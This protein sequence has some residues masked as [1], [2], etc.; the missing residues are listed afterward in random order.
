V[1]AP[2]HETFGMLELQETW[3]SE[4]LKRYAEEILQAAPEGSI[5]FGGTDAGRCAVS[6]YSESHV[7]GRPILTLT[8]NALADT[9]YLNYLNSMYGSRMSVPTP[10]DS[11]QAFQQYMTAAQKRLQQDA[12]LPGEQVQM[13]AGRVQ[14]SGQ[15]AVMQINGLLVLKTLEKN[16]GRDFYLEE[17]FAVQML[18][19]H[20]EPCGPIFRLHREA[21]E[22]LGKGLIQANHLYWTDFLQE[23]FGE[24][25]ASITNLDAVLLYLDGNYDSDFQSGEAPSS[26]LKSVEARKAF[27]KLRGS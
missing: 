19:P 7:G 5:Y 26:L 8:Q 20:M 14:V 6:C 16:P 1:W 21:R 27:A 11:Q 12:L 23:I 9:S 4:W 17:S 13:N 24:R 15:T 18:N 25:V 2:I 3:G 10:A 22:G